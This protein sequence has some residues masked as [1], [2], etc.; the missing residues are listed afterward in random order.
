M[1]DQI[2]QSLD[3]DKKGY[4]GYQD[5]CDLAEEKRRN[6]DPFGNEAIKKEQEVDKPEN[7]AR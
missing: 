5:F 3:K 7:Y 2:F 6:I 4:I 1:I